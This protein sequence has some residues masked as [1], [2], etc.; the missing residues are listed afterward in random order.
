M[1]STQALA[2]DA[3]LPAFPTIIA[4]LK[5]SNP[6]HGQW[7]VTAY[8]AGLGAGQ[9]LWGMLSD[10]FGRR[11]V[12][13]GGLALYVVAALLCGFT[14]SFAAL[15]GWRF[16]HGLA[17]ASVT[18]ARSIIRD[19]YSGRTMARVMSLTFVVFLTVPILAPEP[20][21]ADSAG[22]VLARYLHR[23]RRLR[24]RGRR[25]GAGAPARDAA[26]GVSPDA[27]SRLTSPARSSSCSGIA[28]RFATPWR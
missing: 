28:C 3:M 18:V 2:I 9:L 8:M 20:R 24:H 12:L 13:L 11:P 16:V 21:A 5:V 6:N 4:V 1:M 14:G 10:R 17:A 27:R 23:V 25:L 7:I 22:G 26:S 19:L 15:L